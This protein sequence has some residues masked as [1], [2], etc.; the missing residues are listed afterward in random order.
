MVE[1]EEVDT[2]L[3]GVGRVNQV[4][5]GRDT[6]LAQ[7]RVQH[8]A[9]LRRHPLIPR[10]PGEGAQQ[11]SDACDSDAGAGRKATSARHLSTNR[12]KRSILLS[13]FGISHSLS[14]TTALRAADILHLRRI[15][16]NL[17]WFRLVDLRL[18]HRS[19]CLSRASFLRRSV[20]WEAGA[21]STFDHFVSVSV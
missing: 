14:S 20:S 16:I 18:A 1:V 10:I 9:E 4:R 13:R 12:A 21:T 2:G 11:L 8:L 5:E 19:L 17:F 15:S 7:A 6:L 3:A